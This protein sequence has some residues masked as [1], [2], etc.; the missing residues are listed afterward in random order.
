MNVSQY[1]VKYLEKKGIKNIFLVTGGGMMFL[2]DALSKSKIKLMH[3]HHEQAA[4]FSADGFSR[5]AEKVSVCCATSGPG[6]TNLA[7]GI[8][9]AW[10]DSIPV[11]IF[12]GQSE[13][14]ETIEHTKHKKIRQ[15]GTFEVNSIKLYSSIT[16]FAKSISDP[17]DIK[18]YLDKA[19]NLAETGRPG[20][21]FLELP[22]DIQSSKIDN[23]NLNRKKYY[24]KKKDSKNNLRKSIKK[25]LA[26]FKNSKRPLVLAGYGIRASKCVKEFR[27]FVAKNNLPTVTTQFAKDVLYYDSKNF[28]GHSGPKGDR[29]GNTA[30]QQAD[31]ILIIGCSLHSQTIGWEKSLFAPKAKKTQID[32]DLEVLKKDIP[33]IKNKFNVDVS[34]FVKELRKYKLNNKDHLKWHKRCLDLK[35][36][37][38]VINEPHQRKKKLINYYDF[39]FEISK[40]LPK[41]AAVVTDAGAA[42]YILGQSMRIK[43][44]QRYIVCASHGTMGYAL[45]ASNG[46]SLNKKISSVCI[47]GDGSLMTNLHD[48]GTTSINKLD[49][50]IFVIN[51]SGYMSIRNNQKEFFGG[52]SFGTDSSNGV[53][54]PKFKE[55]AKTFKIPYHSIKSKNKIKEV[56]KKIFKKKGPIFIEVFCSDTKI[57]PTVK[58]KLNNKGKLVSNPLDKM[59][60]YL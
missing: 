29:A 42:Y 58:S 26:E 37:F 35:N 22:L 34:S 30:I 11:V 50:K 36:K 52:K 32:I 9:H 4:F 44:D 25:T 57:I 12:G 38:Q 59:F 33:N 60:P 47:T 7:T 49:V 27:E 46:A 17:Q 2:T 56:S 41:N 21:V 6:I 8:L 1:I 54:M 19:F 43:K 20:P 51:N 55:I 10:Q 53:F 28:I 5:A 31:Y 39:V 3:N 24:S 15:L 14:K 48:L 13:K 40:Y 23:L 18:F 16:K 45:S